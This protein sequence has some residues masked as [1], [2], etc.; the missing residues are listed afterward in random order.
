[1]ENAKRSREGT[2]R[3]QLRQFICGVTLLA[4]GLAAAG[5]WPPVTLAGEADLPRLAVLP[6][7]IEDTSGEAGAAD[8]H[9]A[10]LAS[11]TRFIS[12]AIAAAGI[13]DVVDPARVKQAVEAENPGTYLRACNGCEFDIAN[14]VGADRVMIGWLFKMSTLVLSLHVVIKDVAT[15]NIIYAKTFDF[16]GDN[17]KSWKRAADYMVKAIKSRNEASRNPTN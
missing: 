16:R 6:I 14:S 15:G 11:L 17:E 7:E 3:R 4:A 1:M 8:R 13:Y 9:D 5:V 2:A 10:M 12:E